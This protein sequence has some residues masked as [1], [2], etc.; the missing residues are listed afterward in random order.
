MQIEQKELDTRQMRENVKRKMLQI[1]V[2]AERNRISEEET[3]Y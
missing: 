1:A 3:F 2:I